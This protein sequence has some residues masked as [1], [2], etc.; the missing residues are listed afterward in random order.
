MAQLAEQEARAVKLEADAVDTVVVSNMGSHGDD[1]KQM[2]ADASIRYVFYM[3]TNHVHF[4]SCHLLMKHY[5]S[6]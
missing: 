2:K 1:A 3:P 6:F 4:V 5:L